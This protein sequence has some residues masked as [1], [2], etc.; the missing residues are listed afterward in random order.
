MPTRADLE[1]R[2]AGSGATGWELVEAAQR[3]V[4]DGIRRYSC[5]RWWESPDRALERGAAYC[6]QYNGVLAELLRS[7]GV[8][9]RRVYA[10]RVEV[11]DDP[12][13]RGGHVWVRARVDDEERDVCAG[14]DANRPGAVGFVPASRV[15]TFG[16]PAQAVATAGL[17]GLVAA[18]LAWAR[19]RG[20]PRP[21]WM[22]RAFDR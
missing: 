10:T 14:R 1:R 21:E 15:R 8:E 7:A 16:R 13:W 12:T 2:L 5:L 9:A 6:V 11:A 18:Q 4:H 22:D 17:A 20:R 19:V 3:L